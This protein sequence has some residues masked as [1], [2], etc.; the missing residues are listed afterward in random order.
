MSFFNRGLQWLFDDASFYPLNVISYS[1]FFENFCPTRVLTL[2][3]R[4]V[5][6]HDIPLLFPCLGR[7]AV[8]MFSKSRQE[9]LSV[10]VFLW[11]VCWSVAVTSGRMEKRQVCA[12]KSHGK[13]DEN[14][15][16]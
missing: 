11:V 13:L 12:L 10:Y 1:M 14:E 7:E 15:D 8:V 2:L 5:M 3:S 9:I 4:G 16:E 6:T